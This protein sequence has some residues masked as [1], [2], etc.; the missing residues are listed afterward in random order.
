ML[1][2]ERAS[3]RWMWVKRCRCCG[4]RGWNW[5]AF[6]RMMMP[7]VEWSENNRANIHTCERTV[8]INIM[9]IPYLFLCSAPAETLLFPSFLL[10]ARSRS[11]VPSLSSTMENL[12]S[13]PCNFRR[14]SFHSS[15]IILLLLIS[16]PFLETLIDAGKKTEVKWRS[17]LRWCWCWW[18]WKKEQ[19]KERSR[20]ENKK[21][22]K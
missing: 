18:W 17:K 3:I 4:R 11:L 22:S 13:F 12:E 1:D 6:T 19:K 20:R 2:R 5:I 10:L 16:R 15:H 14:C 7:M 9:Q 21:F 8:K